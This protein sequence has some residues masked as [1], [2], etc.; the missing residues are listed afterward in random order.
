MKSLY[1]IKCFED[2]KLKNI[3]VE[4]IIKCINNDGFIET[5]IIK[6]YPG[7]INEPVRPI[8]VDNDGEISVEI[9]SKMYSVDL[10][11]VKKIIY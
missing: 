11:D 8:S 9:Q 1:Y 7:K 4:D 3:T 2:F 10:Q 5:D 6:D